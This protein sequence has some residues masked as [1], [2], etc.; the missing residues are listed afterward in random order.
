MV[1]LEPSMVMDFPATEAVIGALPPVRLTVNVTLPAD[2][3]TDVRIAVIPGAG[4][5]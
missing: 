4:A 3:Y 5:G 2:E 1:P